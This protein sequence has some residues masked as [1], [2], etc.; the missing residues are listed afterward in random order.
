METK[1]NFTKPKITEEEIALINRLIAENPSWGR[2]KLSQELC[3]IWNWCGPNGQIK[4]ISCRA[5][6]RKL[7]AKGLIK[8][9]PRICNGRKA[10]SRDKV[11][12]M[13]HDTTP[14][15]V[16]IRDLLPLK[17][18]VIRKSGPLLTEFKSLLVQYHYLGFDMTVG[19]NMKYMVYSRD[20]I[21]L[22]CLLFGSAAWSC[23]PRDKFIGWEATARKNN[24]Y[25]ITNNTRFLILPWVKVPHLASHILGLICRRISSDWQEKYGHSVY[26]LETFVERDRFKGT[27]YKAANWIHV[28]ETTGRSRNDRYNNLRV[29]I[30]DIFLY[31]LNKNFREVLAYDATP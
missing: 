16:S 8:L 10:G 6:L 25:L 26:L 30:K 7:D 22:S 4:D 9:P 27:C 19:E 14:V 17:V 1:R 31:P 28:G 11:Q 23:A 29:P 2:S 5:L 12:V 20:G 18:E 15:T 21:L 3:R 13:T 24:L